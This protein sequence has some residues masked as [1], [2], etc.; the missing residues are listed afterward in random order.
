VRWVEILPCLAIAVGA[1]SCGSTTPRPPAA[2][3]IASLPE[4]EFPPRVSFAPDCVAHFE[5]SA[6]V[7]VPSDLPQELIHVTFENRMSSHFRLRSVGFVLNGTL[8]AHSAVEEGL[9]ERYNEESQTWELTT[10]SG[11]NVLDAYVSYRSFSSCVYC[12]IRSFCFGV[13][14]R[15]RVTVEPG[16]SVG[17]DIAAH[18]Q[19]G[20][21]TPIEERPVLRFTERR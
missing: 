17:I 6:R 7:P 18:E 20:P 13:R 11:E 12:Y 16:R 9:E 10:V 19:G 14:A 21:T 5:S 15:Y 8:V 1:T 2:N 3:H 4:G